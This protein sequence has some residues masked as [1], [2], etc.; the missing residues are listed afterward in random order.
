[1]DF[2]FKLGSDGKAGLGGMSHQAVSAHIP[3]SMKAKLNGE[4]STASATD[5]DDID[6]DQEVLLPG[7]C[8]RCGRSSS[9][10]KC[11]VP[12]PPHLRVDKG[13]VQNREGYKN[14]FQCLACRQL[15]TTLSQSFSCGNNV[16]VEGP[17]F[18]FRGKHISTLLPESDD[19]RIHKGLVNIDG[20]GNMQPRIKDVLDLQRQAGVKTLTISGQSDETFPVTLS[21]RA[22]N[23]TTL[24]IIDMHIKTLHLTEDLTPRLT[25]LELRNVPSDCDFKVIVPTL[26]NVSI[27]FLTPDGEAAVINDMLAAATRLEKF[28]SYKLWVGEE[29]RFASNMLEIIDLHRSDGLEALSI[30]APNLQHLGLQACYCMEK[31]TVLKEHPKLSKELPVGHIP[32]TFTVN[33]LNANISKAARRVLKKSGRSLIQDADPANSP[34]ASMEATHQKTHQMTSKGMDMAEMMTALNSQFLGANLG[35]SQSG[36]GGGGQRRSPSQSG[37]GKDMPSECAQQ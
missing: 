18:C 15:I 20:P 17:K 26:K 8:G 36:G 30:W 34:M 32:T 19:R 11:E 4:K 3:A 22:S 31:I 29:L 21:Y 10:G 37:N 23:L 2:G 14:S 33:T 35:A 6:E 16:I 25:D 1:M 5:I 7:M 12:H 9:K 13:S 28:D 24:K 27:Q